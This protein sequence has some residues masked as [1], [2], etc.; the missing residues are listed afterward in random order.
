VPAAEIPQD[1][2]IVETMQDASAAIGRRG[3][4]TGMDSWHDG[5]SF[6][7]SG[8]PAICFGP[9]DLTLAHTTDESVPVDELVQCAQALAVA[10]MRWCGVADEAG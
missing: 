7:L 9:G 2:P 3:R 6:I 4:I 8:T 1:H 5:A 10:A